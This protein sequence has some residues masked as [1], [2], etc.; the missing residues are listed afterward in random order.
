MDQ[1]NVSLNL[2]MNMAKSIRAK[3][4]FRPEKLEEV[5]RV[6]IP[7]AGVITTCPYN[8]NKRSKE[9]GLARPG[10]G[11]LIKAAV[12]GSK[13]DNGGGGEATRRRCQQHERKYRP[14]TCLNI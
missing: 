4:S 8:G 5:I 6:L 1:R 3:S 14:L 7:K 9:L 2:L 11:L 10:E 13:D 12:Q